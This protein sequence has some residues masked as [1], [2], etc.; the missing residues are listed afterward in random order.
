[1]VVDAKPDEA[2]PAEPAPND[3]PQS[4]RFAKTT[5]ADYVTVEFR[6][7]VDAATEEAIYLA[8]AAAVAGDSDLLPATA[9][10]ADALA[11]QAGPVA[12]V[13]AFSQRLRIG[14]IV[15][16][17]AERRRIVVELVKEPCTK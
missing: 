13:T 14:R 5:E 11:V 16:V 8:L 2:Q 1:V 12:D 10:S 17:D 3:P 7:P 4:V 6:G 9:E 15:S